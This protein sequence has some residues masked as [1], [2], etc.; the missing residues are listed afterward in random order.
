[1]NWIR[2]RWL[3]VT[4]MVLLGLLSLLQ[5][6]DLRV[7]G[8]FRSQVTAQSHYIQVE[9]EI[10]S[11]F[12]VRDILLVAVPSEDPQTVNRVAGIIR[13][14][15]GISL[16]VNP[17]E[18]PFTIGGKS[19]I[20]QQLGLVGK[21]R[22]K[23]YAILVAVISSRPEDTA[24]RIERATKQYGTSLFGN[25]YISVK[26]LEYI[27]FILKFLSPLAVVVI[28]TVFYLTLRNF[29]AT[30]LSFLPSLL[31]TVYMLGAYSVFGK[32]ITLENVLMPFITLV[33][34]SAA[35]LHYISH[36][37]SLADFNVFERAQK[38]L[39]ETFV[40]LLMT[41]ATTVVGFLSMCFTS[42]PVMS[43]LGLSGACGVGMAGLSTFI[44]LPPM[45][46]FLRSQRKQSKGERLTKF[47]LRYRRL[48]LIILLIVSVILCLFIL[49][50]KEEF[51]ALMF[52]RRSS[53]V[54]EGA[55]IVEAISGVSIP[56][57]VKINFEVDPLSKDALE[58][59][60]NLRKA[61]SS[62]SRRTL[63]I[64]EIK[65]LLPSVLGNVVPIILPEGIFVNRKD[66]SALMLVFLKDLSRK[67]HYSFQQAVES[68]SMNGLSSVHVTG[69]NYKYL[70]MNDE[71]L[72]N[73]KV[74]IVVALFVIG[75]MMV[76][77][78][79]DLKFGLISTVPVVLTILNLY[80]FLGLFQIPLNVISAY[81]MNIALGAGID[82]AI[83]FTYTYKT[84]YK[85][86]KLYALSQTLQITGKPILANAVGIAVGFS[87]LLFSP[88]SVHV[89]I[90]VL[91]FIAMIMASLYTLF[92]LTWMKRERC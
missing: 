51:H 28:F 62:Y 89:H 47:F 26:A 91:I 6:K 66:K 61:A 2:K 71:T 21:Y 9:R 60:E 64:L 17:M 81:I 58:I 33:M 48:N 32:T 4:L 73:Q 74:S 88:M 31:A 83:H 55:R 37:L 30:V 75:F 22:G 46:T 1:M 76:L 38:A 14:T 56:V 40:P 53:K 50:V 36:Y 11:A 43:E 84:I 13:E 19:S 25:S 90:A 57:L 87:V 72:S 52:F 69:E 12:A 86:R 78:L 77:M 3:F 42:S 24:L 85:S 7:G 29:W 39:K 18:F 35:G 34:G 27:G 80:G 23:N 82:Y 41:T 49:K 15:R 65:E 20:A 59:L 68:F 63:S 16:V 79:R 92:W 44:F 54:M 5:L 70:Q 45:A 10:T 8:Y 67:T